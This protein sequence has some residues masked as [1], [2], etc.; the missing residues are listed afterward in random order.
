METL[1]LKAEVR[2]VTGK[3]VKKLRRE[4]L[5]PAVL[6]G[7]NVEAMQLQI[8]GKTLGKVLASGGSHGLISLQI[9][10]KRSQMALAREIQRDPISQSYLHV[11]FYAVNMDQKITAEIPIVLEGVSPA[12]KDQDGI[13]TQNLTQLEV[14]CL[15]GDLIPS[16]NVDISKLVELNVAIT[17]AELNVPSVFTVLTD[18]DTVVVRTEAPRSAEAFEAIVEEGKEVSA[19]PEVVARGREEEGKKNED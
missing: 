11:D 18:P 3:D 1:N 17:V 13:L 8:D 4:G 6:Y 2:Q 12:V 16:I 10:D 5:V 7:R 19:E 15:P 9:G 14:E